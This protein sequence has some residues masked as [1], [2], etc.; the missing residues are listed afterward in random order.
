M[1]KIYISGALTGIENPEEVKGFYE[2]IA[3]L[4]SKQGHDPYVPHLKT[5]P[6]KNPDVTTRQVYDNDKTQVESSDL[7][8]AY[9]GIPS[10]GVGMELAFAAIKQIPVILLAE[11]G[12]IISRFPRGIPSLMAEVY[13]DDYQDALEKLHQLLV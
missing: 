9:V 6:I 2:A 11:K 10:L 12:K 4:C 5:D 7:V 13:F 3:Q 1:K 8:I